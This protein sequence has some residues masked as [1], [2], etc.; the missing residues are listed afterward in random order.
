MLRKTALRG[1]GRTRQARG[2]N[3]RFHHHRFV[4]DQKP[5]FGQQRSERA[6][7]RSGVHHA[8]SP[9]PCRVCDIYSRVPT[10]ATGVTVG[11]AAVEQDMAGQVAPRFGSPRS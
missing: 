10:L 7:P 3:P 2:P 8:P 5:R 4:V 1:A 9:V 6:D 11:L